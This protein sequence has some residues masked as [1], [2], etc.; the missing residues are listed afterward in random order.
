M[1]GLKLML[2]VLTIASFLPVFPAAAG[3]NGLCDWTELVGHDT[4]EQPKTGDLTCDQDGVSFSGETKYYVDGQGGGAFGG[5]YN[6]PVKSSDIRVELTI[7]ELADGA[8]EDA[9][10]SVSFLDAKKFFN[11]FNTLDPGGVVTLLRNDGG[12]VSAQVDGYAP[13]GAT[14]HRTL[15][16]KTTGVAVGQKL[17]LRLKRDFAGRWHYSVNGVRFDGSGELVDLPA[18]L[19]AGKD[20][21]V[22]VGVHNVNG[23]ETSFRVS[24]ISSGAQ[25]EPETDGQK[26]FNERIFANPPLQYRPLRIIH[27]NLTTSMIDDL[28][29]LGYGGIVTNVPYSDYL[30]SETNWNTLVD[31]VE[32][33]IDEA[34]LRMWIY[35]EEGYPSGGAGGIVLR[36]RPDLEAQGLATIVRET[37]GSETITIPH[38]TG[39]GEVVLAAAYEGTRDNFSAATMTDLRPFLDA[40]GSLNWSAPAGDRV[41]FYMVQKPFYEGSHAANNWFEQRRYVN[42]LEKEAA[43]TFVDWTHEQYFERLG[44]YFGNG[45]EAFFTDEPSLLGTYLDPPPVTPLV[46]DVPDPNVPLL[47]SLNWGNALL[48]DFELKRGYDLYPFLPYLAGGDD[49]QAK[50]VRWDFYRT[51]S[52]LLEDN[53]FGTLQGF[54]TDKGVACTGHLLLEEDLFHHAV[55]EGN[56]MSIYRRMDYP[57][58]D[59]LTAYPWIA[60]VWGVTTAKLASSVAKHEG[61]PHVHSEISNAFDGSEAGITGRLGSIA[62]QFA[63]GVDTFTSYYV[64]TQMS[65]ADNRLFTD[66]V[67]R[68]GYLLDGGKSVAETALYYPIE[69]VWAHTL[70]PQSIH[71]EDFAP[72]A[73]DVSESLKQTALQL[74]GSQLDF[75]YV[76]EESVLEAGTAEGKLVTADGSAYRTLVVPRVSVMSESALD[77]L[78][79][80]ADAGVAIVMLDS[81]NVIGE[82]GTTAGDIQDAYDGLLAHPNVT[83]VV[84]ESAIPAAVKAAIEPDFALDQPDSAIIYRKQKIGDSYAYLIVNTSENPAQFEASFNVSLERARIWDPLTGSVVPLPLKTKN[85]RLTADLTFAGRQGMVVTFEPEAADWTILGGQDAG[86]AV[87]DGAVANSGGGLTFVGDAKYYVDGQGGGAFGGIFNRPVYADDIEVEMEIGELADEALQD[88]WVSLSFLDGKKFFNIF[89]TLDPGGVVTLLRNDGGVLKAQV[90]GYA[91]FGGGSMQRTLMVKTLDADVGEAF[92]IRLK[93]DAVSGKWGYYVNGTRLDTGGELDDLPG[94]LFDGKNVYVVVGLHNA[95]GGL[96]SFTVKRISS[97]E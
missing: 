41:V 97:G 4:N 31:N 16:N 93:R 9:W 42:L 11:I 45:I 79:T 8:V 50:Q 33:A 2:A 10:V 69:S 89:N 37:S 17:E 14:N 23:H 70:P 49:A 26:V 43:E 63:Y 72:G 88:A 56:L 91:D 71:A 28:K 51:L 65:N 87:R 82:R 80:L 84:G 74:V 76:D 47:P 55:F 27:D 7:E 21:Y 81:G 39:H 29:N 52:E 18:S 54:C 48:D 66:Y 13:F 61:K 1:R 67:G 12:I 25:Y 35:D 62:V 90:D 22:V 75:D 40:G 20:V 86:G 6:R 53:Y 59:L 19:F 44:S 85:G 57:G 95:N 38:P 30:E 15:L 32:Y 5:I 68:L 34:G 77:K 60:K 3:A 78:E 58:I 46:R 24:R 36:E 96:T 83:S 94:G 92:A 73:V 64:H